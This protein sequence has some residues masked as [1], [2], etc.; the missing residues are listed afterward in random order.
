MSEALPILAAAELEDEGSEE[1]QEAEEM[2]ME[3]VRTR[4]T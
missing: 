1:R 2:A 4:A 3:R